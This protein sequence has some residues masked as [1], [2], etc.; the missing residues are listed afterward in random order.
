M[1]LVE[2]VLLTV[3]CLQTLMAVWPV[4]SYLILKSF[5]KNCLSIM[6]AVIKRCRVKLLCSEFLIDGYFVP[7]AVIYLNLCFYP[8]LVGYL[9]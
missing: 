8:L 7:S 4:P 6:D 5:F 1:H 3:I 9:D 2:S